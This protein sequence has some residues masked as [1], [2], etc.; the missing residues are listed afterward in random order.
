M[1]TAEA[2]LH[3]LYALWRGAKIGSSS[4]AVAEGIASSE[5][6]EETQMSPKERQERLKE[7]W[8]SLSPAEREQLEHA[9]RYSTDA[10]VRMRARAVKCC[11]EGESCRAAARRLGCSDRFVRLATER[12]IERGLEALS[13]ARFLRKGPRHLTPELAELLEKA[14]QLGPGAFGYEWNRWTLQRLVRLVE[15]QMGLRLSVG[16]MC[17]YLRQLGIE[18]LRGRPHVDTP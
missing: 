7:R 17:R 3:G 10:T 15:D 12:F 13:D 8:L 1:G 9:A 2:A 6:E 16:T 5:N 4:V 18:G 14:V 11:I